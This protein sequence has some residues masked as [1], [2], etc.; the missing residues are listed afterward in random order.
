MSYKT[1]IKNVL[2]DMRF[3]WENSGGTALANQVEEPVRPIG[4]QEIMIDSLKENLK[5]LA[6]IKQK[7]DS[8]SERLY[9]GMAED[10]RIEFLKFVEEMKIKYDRQ[11]KKLQ[12]TLRFQKD[13]PFFDESHN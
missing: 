12:E 3:H 13:N 4:N 7:L 11:E 5:D 8:L 2:T 6:V 9:L 10:V 1:F